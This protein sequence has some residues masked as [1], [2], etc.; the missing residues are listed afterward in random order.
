MSQ[1]TTLES[2]QA[3]RAI[4]A[5]VVVIFHTA[6]Y[7]HARDLIPEVPRLAT[8]G[9]SGVDIFFVISGF[10]MVLITSGE[11]WE[12]R[13]A[14]EFLARR[15][16]RIVPIY[17][18]YTF[19]MAAAILLFPH[20]VSAGKTT[21]LTHILAS[22][23]FIPWENNIGDVKPVLNVGWTLNFEMYF[24][25]V[26]ALLM[27]VSRV[28]MLAILSTLFGVSI[29]AGLL[30]DAPA[31][32]YVITSTLLLEFLFGCF[33]AHW[34]LSG[35]VLESWVSILCIVAGTAVIVA[36]GIYDVLY[37]LPRVVKW[38]FPAAFVLYGMVSLENR[39]DLTFPR[40]A[41]ALGDSSYSLYLS[42]VFT[43][44]IAGKLCLVFLGTGHVTFIWVAILMS[45]VAG[46]LSYLVLERP[47]TRFLNGQYRR[48][49][50]RAA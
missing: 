6:T 2:V 17:W 12:K 32:L 38:A 23:F 45:I 37:E 14:S 31:L 5:L 50:H 30:I 9:R 3:M 40:F 28:R 8:L 44:S 26:F 48:W 11:A 36:S 35:K 29:V 47:S 7:L 25:L 33:V 46:H 18:F 19:G 15:V 39:N 20:L 4:A 1:K 41:I 13:S 24:Y 10:I 21:D 16:I 27:G 43:I 49:S 42:H 34:Y 22:M